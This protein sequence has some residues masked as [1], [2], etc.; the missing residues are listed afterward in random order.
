MHIF[1]APVTNGDFVPVVLGKGSIQM[2]VTRKN[3]PNVKRNLW[4]HTNFMV[5]TL[6]TKIVK[7][8]TH[9]LDL[10]AFIGIVNLVKHMDIVILAHWMENADQ[11]D[12]L[13]CLW[14]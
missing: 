7:T 6:T 8:A 3:V 14:F 10:I 2:D 1:T 13:I 11:R 12:D 4:N 9:Q 5:Q